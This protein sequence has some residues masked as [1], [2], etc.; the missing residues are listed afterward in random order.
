MTWAAGTRVR[1]VWDPKRDA[2]YVASER[3]KRK[4]VSHC[5]GE[6]TGAVSSGHGLCY[7]V[8]FQR[9]NLTTTHAWFD[10]EEVHLINDEGVLHPRDV[11][12]RVVESVWVHADRCRMAL[13]FADGA[14]AVWRAQGDCCADSW[15]EDVQSLGFKGTVLT[16]GRDPTREDTDVQ[17]SPGG[18]LDTNFLCLTTE[19]GRLLIELRTRHN[20]YYGGSLAGTDEL[21]TGDGW[22]EV[23][24]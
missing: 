23:E 24:L 7:E 4:S 10:A 8:V 19:R 18:Y 17:V 1:V 13:V 22:W 9:T 15:I 6:L 11:V 3:G 21:M 12:G 2:S 20:G 14:Q 16:A 5:V